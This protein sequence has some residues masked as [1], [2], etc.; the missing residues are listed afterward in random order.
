[1]Q[2]NQLTQEYVGSI[3]NSITGGENGG[4]SSVDGLLSVNS[5]ILQAYSGR[6][7]LPFQ[8]DFTEGSFGAFQL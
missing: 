1:M 8:Q 6:R 4:G 3:T 7:A 5:N 2:S